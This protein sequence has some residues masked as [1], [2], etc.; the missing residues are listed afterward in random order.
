M[1]TTGTTSARATTTP[2]EDGNDLRT[3]YHRVRGF[4]EEL[5]EPLSPED[6]T[7]QT[8]P[9]VSPT[10]WHRAHTTW[11]FET[12]VLA[13]YQRGYT[14]FDPAYA[15]LFNSYYET[16]GPRHS[17][18]Q[19]GLLSRPGVAEIGRYRG[20]VD[21][22]M[23]QLLVA[24]G[25]DQA[26][27]VT[28]LVELGLHHEQQ[29]QELLLMDIKHVLAVNPLRPAYRAF[30]RPRAVEAGPD[31]P[32]WIEHAGGVVSV[33][34]AGDGFSFD[35]ETPR[36]DVLLSPFAIR[37]SLVT[38]GDW[39]AFITEGGYREPT[40]WMSDGWA[41]VQAQ[42]WEAPEYW[43]RADDGWLVQ[44][45]AGPRPV[46]PDEPVCH[47]SWYEA[48][49]FARW[50]GCRLPTEAEWEVVAATRAHP[51]AVVAGEVP[52][53]AGLDHA[54][55]AGS[56]LH[57][58]PPA[59]GDEQWFGAV[60]QWTASPYGPYPGFQPA[61]GAVG[62]YNGK[63]M[64]NQQVLRGGACVTPEGHSRPSYRNFFPPAARWPFCGLRLA[65]D[66]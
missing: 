10:K 3:R 55:L 28:E 43:S 51:P 62:E 48:D 59:P 16:V 18:P 63:F 47:I 44:T 7:V 58:A 53:A 37:S 25:T 29:H 57:P 12:F 23:D 17:R 61:A 11:F 5:A 60:W 52:S 24:G 20:Q 1:P 22:F 15:F 9:D 49:A 42:E 45:L 66:R 64:V 8:M 34:Y 56:G 32:A 19:R 21:D 13:P 38:A 36:H 26:A 54:G 14:E 4:T 30:E 40:L 46:D 33:G 31:G 27:R 39:L 65:V 35:N 6:Q 2:A 50:A 41:T